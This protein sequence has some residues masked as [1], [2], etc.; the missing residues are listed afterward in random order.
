VPAAAF[1][2]DVEEAFL[3]LAGSRRR[4]ASEHFR[5]AAKEAGLDEHGRRTLALL[6]REYGFDIENK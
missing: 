2:K 3:R 5:E 4:I 1:L 6:L